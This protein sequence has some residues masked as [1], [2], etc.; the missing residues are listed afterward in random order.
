M[1]IPASKETAGWGF[2]S[3]RR[4]GAGGTG[5]R[6]SSHSRAQEVAFD[7]MSQRRSCPQSLEL[8]L[9]HPCDMT[10]CG[11]WTSLSNCARTALNIVGLPAMQFVARQPTTDTL[12]RFHS[13]TLTPRAAR[14]PVPFLAF[15]IIARPWSSAPLPTRV[16]SVPKLLAPR[17][18]KSS[19]PHQLRRP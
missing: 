2:V 9:Q 1:N 12:S 6:R 4:A 10:D 5:P 14:Q 17:T 8:P 11:L 3:S 16:H 13:F 7:L 19:S 15:H 18:S